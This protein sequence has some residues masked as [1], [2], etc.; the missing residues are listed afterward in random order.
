M[1]HCLPLRSERGAEEL[2]IEAQAVLLKLSIDC[3]VNSDQVHANYANEIEQMAHALD[4]A[5]ANPAA[6]LSAEELWTSLTDLLF[7]YDAHIQDTLSSN[8]D[9]QATAYLLGRGLAEAYWALDPGGP[10]GTVTSWSFLLG[11]ERCT[12]LSRG[13]GRLTAYFSPYTAAAISGSLVAW[14]KVASDG[15]WR[16]QPGAAATLY[17]QIRGWYELLVL[18]QDPS[19]L[20]APY[21]ILKSW[22]AAT[23]AIRTFAV[24]LVTLGV[25]LALLVLLAFLSTYGKT[26]AG[27]N[28]VLGIVSGLGITAAAVQTNLKNTAQAATTRLRQDVYTDLVAGDVTTLPDLPGKSKEAMRKLT[29][30]ACQERTLTTAQAA[31]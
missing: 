9:K 8:S 21:A 4:T 27:A 16:A 14:K 18:G 26:N 5:R 25:S 24:Q 19:T 23:Q 15:T 28:T 6:D 31:A 11:N 2:R 30:Q 3:G 22:R 1:G 29:I 13:V 10:D 20:I 7:H 17:L 12:E